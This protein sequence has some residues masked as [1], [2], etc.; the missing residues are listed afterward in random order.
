MAK[1]AHCRGTTGYRLPT[2]KHPP[3]GGP[4]R[5]PPGPRARAGAPGPAPG[6]RGPPP[7]GPAPGPPGGPSG[8]PLPDHLG[9]PPDRRSARGPDDE[10]R[11]AASLVVRTPTDGCRRM[12]P[13]PGR[14]PIR[15][16]GR[17]GRVAEGY[18][19]RH[20]GGPRSSPPEKSVRRT[21]GGCK[22]P[23]RRP[24]TP[25]VRLGPGHSQVAEQLANTERSEWRRAERRP[26]EPT[27][28]GRVEGGGGAPG[29]ARWGRR[30]QRAGPTE[31]PRE[32]DGSAVAV[33][34]CRER[35]E[36]RRERGPSETRRELAW[37][38]GQMRSGPWRWATGVAALRCSLIAQ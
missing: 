29:G 15:G 34:A 27:V 35:A 20:S 11:G 36:T 9:T 1:T 31:T 7:G 3:P 5:G 2:P 38:A 30:A 12:G 23:G 18:A 8:T 14:G 26:Q 6:P 17:G 10:R 16:G 28:G 19:V 13:R 22:R 33:W 24:E 4:P 21:E 37:E 25:W 32:G